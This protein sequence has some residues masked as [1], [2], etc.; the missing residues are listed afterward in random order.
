VLF[1]LDQL[2][3]WNDHDPILAGRLD[4]ERIATMGF[5]WGAE[6]AGEAARVDARCRAAILLDEPFVFPELL[7]FGLQKPLLL[8]RAELADLTLYNKNTQDAVFFQ[9]NSI[10][11]GQLVDYYWLANP[12][13]VMDGREAA[14]TLC[15]YTVWFLDKYLKG[16]SNPTPDPRN[17]RLLSNFKQK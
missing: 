5:S 2:P 14:R 13:D 8:V 16:I 9:L 3:G 17:Y 6:S 7:R 10:S 15:D 12:G 11:H 1:V 4:L